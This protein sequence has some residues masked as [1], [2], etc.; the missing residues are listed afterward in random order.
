M[1]YGAGSG[2]NSPLFGRDGARSFLGGAIS[3]TPPH[4]GVPSVSP[5]GAASPFTGAGIEGGGAGELAGGGRTEGRS[6]ACSR[7]ARSRLARSRV[8][9]S[10][11]LPPPRGGRFPARSAAPRFASP[12]ASAPGFPSPRPRPRPASV[13]SSRAPSRSR[14]LASP[15]RPESARPSAAPG[16]SSRSGTDGSCRQPRPPVAIRVPAAS[17]AASRPTFP[18]RTRRRSAEWPR[19]RRRFTS[20]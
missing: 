11:L 16:S 5:A 18:H 10:F 7:P 20:R 1:P 3:S 17:S 2:V 4:R 14:S 15:L 6:L 8:A 12:R 19:A 13:R 9:R